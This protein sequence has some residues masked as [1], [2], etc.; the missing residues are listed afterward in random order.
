MLAH[1]LRNPLAPIRN[2]LA[3]LGMDEDAANDTAWAREVIERQVQ[4]MVRLVD[5]LLDVSR[6]MRGKI[7][8]RKEPVELATVISHA[9]ETARPVLDALKHELFVST[10]AEPIWLDADTVRLTQVIA[11]LLN[12]AAKY[13]EQGGRI[14]LSSERQGDQAVVRVRDNGIGIN[15]EML[16][17]IFDLFTQVNQH[18]ERS[19]GGLGIGLTVVRSL[20][21]MH[22]G[23]VV[24]RSD[25]P[26]QG[27]EFL[28]RLPVLTRPRRGEVHDEPTRPAVEPVRRRVLIVDDNNDSAR[29]LARVIGRIGGH[30]VR[31][32]HDGREGIELVESF[33]PDIVI[34][35]IG[36]PG[37]NGYEVARRLRA[38]PGGDRL[39]L[40]AMTGYGQEEDRR[41]SRDAGFDRHLVKPVAVEALSELFRPIE[42]DEGC[43]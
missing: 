39:F 43:T 26:G 21:E 33:Q 18:D 20:I 14:A 34:L 38:L 29:S 28:I 36:L 6:I 8:L 3:L 23:S 1:E 11:N 25:G 12:N 5:D 32:A 7:S 31:T 37:M 9:V 4:H 16:P 27:S 15:S 10:P 22:G 30:E 35:D 19:Q 42:A 24:A 13:T 17:R 2:A 40:V 41:R